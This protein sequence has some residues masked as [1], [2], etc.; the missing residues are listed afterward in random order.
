MP[1]MWVV[2]CSLEKT[3]HSPG[4][5]QVLPANRRQALK[6]GEHFAN[7]KV[8]E[9]GYLA[10]PKRIDQMNFLSAFAGLE[11]DFVGIR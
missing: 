1:K 4:L 6:K 7:S 8:Q 5:M 11:A 9:G 2:S 10:E 3:L